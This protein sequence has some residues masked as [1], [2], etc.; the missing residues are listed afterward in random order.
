VAVM[1]TKKSTDHLH[2]KNTARDATDLC[3]NVI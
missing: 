1:Y 3:G 2:V